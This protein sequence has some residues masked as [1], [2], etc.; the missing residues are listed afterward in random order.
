M[1]AVALATAIWPAVGAMVF[2]VL[3]AALSTV[4]AVLAALAVRWV[5]GLAWR[6]ELRAM[7]GVDTAPYGA[8]PVVPTLAEL[9]QSA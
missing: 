6:R 5:R 8:A 1:V 9:R 3:V 4:A 7:P 2:G